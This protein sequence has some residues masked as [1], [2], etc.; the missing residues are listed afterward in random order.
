MDGPALDHARSFARSIRGAF[1]LLDEET[2]VGRVVVGRKYTFDFCALKGST[3]TEDLSRRDFTINAMAAPL[4]QVMEGVLNVID[5]CHGERDLQRRR[6]AAVS[7]R[8]FADDPLRLLRAFRFAAQLDLTIERQTCRWIERDAAR[9]PQVAGERI[10]DELATLL[11]Q[12][13]AT[14]WVRQMQAYGVLKAAIPEIACLYTEPDPAFRLFSQVETWLARPEELPLP[15]MRR[16]LRPM[17][18]Q[19][20]A[21]DR[22]WPW[23]VRLAALLHGDTLFQPRHP[24]WIARVATDRLR[25][26]SREHRSLKRLLLL[27]HRVIPLRAQHGNADSALYAVAKETEEDTPGVA[28]LTFGLCRLHGYE[29]RQTVSLLKRLLWLDE[30]RQAIRSQPRLITGDDLIRRFSLRPGPRLGR[31]LSRLEEAQTRELIRSRA[32]A[33]EAVRAWLEE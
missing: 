32:E 11:M 9:L 21:G 1:V 19:R 29:D 14:R 26:S 22:L 17:I 16:R 6:L 13:G 28:L 33:L 12:P 15:A 3:L 5:P 24:G 20:I 25:L 30:R 2:K 8:V 23:I 31:L 10:Q 18:R 4:K 27:P 7:E